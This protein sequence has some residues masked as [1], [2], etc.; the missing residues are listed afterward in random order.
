[1]CQV[2][3]DLE[4][5][6]D[7]VTAFRSFSGYLLGLSWCKMIEIEAEKHGI[8]VINDKLEN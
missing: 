7:V 3:L 4:D 6:N 5:T 2:F 1:M 8:Q